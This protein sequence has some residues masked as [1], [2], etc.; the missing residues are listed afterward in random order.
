MWKDTIFSFIYSNQ[1]LENAWKIINWRSGNRKERN[2]G[3]VVSAYMPWDKAA[4]GN[5]AE[6]DYCVV[7][8]PV[9]KN[10]L[11]PPFW[12][13]LASVKGKGSSDCLE[14]DINH[15]FTKTCK[16]KCNSVFFLCHTFTVSV[17]YVQFA[18]DLYPFYWVKVTNNIQIPNLLYEECSK[19]CFIEDQ[20]GVLWL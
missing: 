4:T 9:G 20:L 12:C 1:H 15:T 17:P 6:E 7:T 5:T 16:L 3:H 13:K 18:L 8:L 11:T 10:L 19:R 14:S 2:S